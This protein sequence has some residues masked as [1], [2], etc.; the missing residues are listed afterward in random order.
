MHINVRSLLP[1][2]DMVRIWA[3]STN[4]DIMVLSETWLGR[5]TPDSYIYM[6]GYNIFRTDRHAKGGGVAIYV[7]NSLLATIQLSK[8]VPKQ[9]ELL[10]LKIELSQ[11]C[12]ML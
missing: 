5:S 4:V 10:V 8:S 9:F 2:I 1:K 7:K 3:K 6:E 11:N 12:G